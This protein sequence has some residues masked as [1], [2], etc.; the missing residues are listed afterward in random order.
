M[1]DPSQQNLPLPNCRFAA[2]ILKSV[3]FLK[4]LKL[5]KVLSFSKDHFGYSKN[6]T[7]SETDI[8]KQLE[9]VVEIPG[10]LTGLVRGG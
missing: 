9:A 6:C 5:R 4:S 7:V 10:F 3:Y 1:Q 8:R 2:L